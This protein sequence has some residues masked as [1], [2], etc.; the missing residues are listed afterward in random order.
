MVAAS[1]SKKALVFVL[2]AALFIWAPVADGAQTDVVSIDVDGSNDLSQFAR[3]M[4]VTTD[5]PIL[6]PNN[7]DKSMD[8]PLA[9]VLHDKCSFASG[10]ALL[11]TPRR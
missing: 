5:V 8:L 1:A 10:A 6:S 2:G 7:T 4:Q 9:A 11:S 3:M